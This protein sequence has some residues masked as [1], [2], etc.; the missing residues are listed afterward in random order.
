MKKI[1]IVLFSLLSL[2][3]VQAQNSDEELAAQYYADGE[4][5][6]AEI[7]YRKLL[8]KDPGSVYLYQNYLDCLIKLKSFDEAEKMVARQIKK[9]EDRP[10]YSID[11]GYLYSLRGAEK[12]KT[13]LFEN[14]IK[15]LKPGYAETE[16]LTNAFLKREF[17]DYSIQTIIKGRKNLQ[18]AQAFSDKLIDLYYKTNQPKKVIDECLELLVSD[19]LSLDLVE[20]KL[21]RLID[22]QSETAYL[23]ERV[24]VYLQKNPNV[25]VFDDLIMWVY[26]Q[27]KK[28]N[29]AMRQALAMDKRNNSEGRVLVNL[30]QVCI[31][32]RE[33]DIAISCYEKVIEFGPDGYFYLSAKMGLL[34]TAYQKLQSGKPY[35]TE[36]LDALIT[37]YNEFITLFGKTWNTAETIKELADIYI[38]YKHDLDKGIGLMEEIVS[39]QRLQPHILGNYKLDLG[40]AY[41]MKDMVWDAALLYGQVDKEFKEDPLGQ[42]AK[43]RNARLSYFQ[44][45]F[46]WA[47]QQLDVL[48]TA[49]SQLISNNAIELALTIEDNT[50]L[51][52][53]TDALKEFAHAQLLLFQNRYSEC[54]KI[55]NSLP[56]KYPN[57]SLEDEIAY[58]K[59]K[60]YEKQ[61]DYSKAEE[62]Y[63]TVFE[64][65]G[66][67]ILADNAMF[68]LANL[69]QNVLNRPEDA[70]KLYENLIF[71]FSGSLYVVEA[72][73]RYNALK[74]L[75]P[76][77]PSP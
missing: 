66:Y 74:S 25:L 19:P 71:N 54:L 53:T 8:K 67:D 6:K 77:T 38:Y 73:K 52:S 51:D 39:I 69:Y 1:L 44:G 12:E 35:T 5:D 9:Y 49:T 59:A 33:F 15:N 16:L 18:S 72:R 57:H 50:G 27:Q 61:R 4:F 43:F 17:Y 29:A 3:N 20:S 70:I 68:D 48:K 24:A 64:Y 32:N 11:L 7:L 40:D 60:V 46:D 55:L 23:Q 56:F 63:K 62:Y 30:A 75:Y 14:L 36:E 42:E 45:D 65:F 28:F 41:V 26:I 22:E 76:S 58:T 47:K 13:E 37:R 34:Q 31:S 21:V 2:S 10:L